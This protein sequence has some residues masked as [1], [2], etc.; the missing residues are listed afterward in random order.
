VVVLTVSG[1]RSPATRS[2][3]IEVGVALTASASVGTVVVTPSPGAK[4]TFPK[5][6]R[7]KLVFDRRPPKLPYL[8]L[9]YGGR[10]I[11]ARIGKKFVRVQPCWKE[12]DASRA[13]RLFPTWC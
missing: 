1:S 9:G 3:K 4:A 8:I 10:L 12:L 11:P 7:R 6:K 5:L 2:R 13:I